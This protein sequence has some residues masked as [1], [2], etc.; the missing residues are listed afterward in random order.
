MTMRNKKNKKSEGG[1]RKTRKLSKGAA[2][3]RN[4]VMKVYREMK[5]KNKDVKFKDA[6]VRASQLKKKGQ[7]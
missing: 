7:L 5:A 6:L 1:R 2:D 3:W 4:S